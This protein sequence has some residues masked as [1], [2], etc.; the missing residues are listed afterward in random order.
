MRQALPK[1]AASA[2]QHRGD[3][4]PIGQLHLTFY[5][6]TVIHLGTIDLDHVLIYR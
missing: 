4:F 1:L 2:Y 3:R 5:C 6:S